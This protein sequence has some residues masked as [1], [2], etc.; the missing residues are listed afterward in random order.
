MVIHDL[1]DNRGRSVIQPIAY[2]GF[3]GVALEET[4]K[5]GVIWVSPKPC[6]QNIT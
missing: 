1:K 2:A 3:G 5:E 6:P 4:L